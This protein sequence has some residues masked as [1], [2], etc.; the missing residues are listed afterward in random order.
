MSVTIT[1]PDGATR[2]YAGSVNGAEI[3]ASIGPGLAK[4]AIVMRVDGRPMNGVEDASAAYAWLRVT[5]RFTIDVVREDRRCI[6]QHGGGRTTENEQ[7]TLHLI[8]PCYSPF[9]RGT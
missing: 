8:L 4:A 9:I 1:L 3:A 5:N 2:T 6:Q 7:P